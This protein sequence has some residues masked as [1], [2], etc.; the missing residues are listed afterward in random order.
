MKQYT[1]AAIAV[2]TIVSI[3]STGC[4]TKQSIQSGISAT[5]ENA[6]CILQPDSDTF[7]LVAYDSVNIIGVKCSIQVGYPN[8][9]GHLATSIKKFIARELT[10]LYLPLNN[11]DEEDESVL[12]EYPAYNGNIDDGLQMIDYYGNGTIRYLLDA[13]KGLEAERT[14]KNEMPILSQQII[15]DKDEITPAYI[16][17]CVIGNSYLGGA[18]HSYTF[19]CRNISR[20]TNMP[21]D[22]MINRD[23]LRNLQPLLRKSVLQCIKNSGV[24]SVTDST[25]DNYVILSDD[26]LVPLPVHEPWLEQGRLQFVYQP[27]EIASYAVGAIS[28]SVAVEDVVPYLSE[29]AKSLLN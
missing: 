8:G 7:P 3:C 17:Y 18:H 25:L 24:E 22:N 14:Q 6:G 4:K 5:D 13:R 28:F 26:G 20:K 11:S 12:R 29:D 9:D 21:V 15:I 2:A 16:T 27:Y 1:F 10:S 19:Y 23:C